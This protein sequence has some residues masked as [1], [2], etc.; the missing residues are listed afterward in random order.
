MVYYLKIRTQSQFNKYKRTN[1]SVVWYTDQVSYIDIV[2]KYTTP[3]LG[4]YLFPKI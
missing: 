3:F 1:I 4:E 2:E